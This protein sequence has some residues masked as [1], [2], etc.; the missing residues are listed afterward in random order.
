[1]YKLTFKVGVAHCT[2]F[3]PHLRNFEEVL[4]GALIAVTEL[5]R[6]S[7]IYKD[8]LVRGERGAWG[9]GPQKNFETTF[10]TLA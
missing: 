6:L 2:F 10:F 5:L 8:L 9:L 4:G 7:V 3:R 1:M